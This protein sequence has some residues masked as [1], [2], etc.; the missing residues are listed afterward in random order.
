MTPNK[1]KAPEQQGWLARTAANIRD[2][3]ITMMTPKNVAITAGALV[4]AV[5]VQDADAQSAD[6]QQSATECRLD[7]QGIRVVSKY[8]AH[9]KEFRQDHCQNGSPKVTDKDIEDFVKTNGFNDILKRA[10]QKGHCK[11]EGNMGGNYINSTA[12]ACLKIGRAHV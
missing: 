10:L 12:N 8:N 1:S 6:A 5:A 9:V 7:D 2:G 11:I 4:T 3:L